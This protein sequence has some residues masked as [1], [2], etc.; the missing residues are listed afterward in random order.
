MKRRQLPHI[1]RLKQE[2][3][4]T[5]EMPIPSGTKLLVRAIERDGESVSVSVRG[6]CLHFDYISLHP[7]EFEVIE[8]REGRTTAT[9]EEQLQTPKA[10]QR[11]LWT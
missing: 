9:A 1:V 3:R 8:W 7:S 11:E 4:P 6:R 5:G 10:E 2:I